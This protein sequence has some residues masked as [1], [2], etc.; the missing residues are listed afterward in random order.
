[1]IKF[2]NVHHRATSI[3]LLYLDLIVHSASAGAHDRSC[4]A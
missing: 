2:N 4:W 3:Y 1:L